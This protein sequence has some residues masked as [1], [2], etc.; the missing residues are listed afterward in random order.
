[1][2]QLARGLVIESYTTGFIRGVGGRFPGV[3]DVFLTDVVSIVH[4]VLCYLVIDFIFN[5]S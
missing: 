5:K 2:F 1:M 3:V 4:P